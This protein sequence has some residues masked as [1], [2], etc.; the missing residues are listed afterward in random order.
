M[1]KFLKTFS[2]KSKSEEPKDYSNAEIIDIYNKMKGEW[3]IATAD[4]PNYTLAEKVF[5]DFND[6]NQKNL[7]LHPMYLKFVPQSLLPYPKNYIKCAYYIYLEKL[8]NEKKSELFQAAQT[9]ATS[10]FYDYPSWEKYQKNLSNKA[11]YDDVVFEEG[12]PLSGRSP[13]EEFK[14]LYGSYQISKREY[15]SSPSSKDATDEKMIHDFGYL[16][17]IEEDVGCDE[18]SNN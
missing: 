2:K 12:D 1:K 8:K 5:L 9:V 13:R 7:N 11:M 15:D 10:L 4:E 18:I 17:E 6:F 16:P 14:K 3:D